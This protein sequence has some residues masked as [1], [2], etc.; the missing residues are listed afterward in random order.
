MSW[1]IVKQSMRAA[2][3][4]V[5]LAFTGASLI[6]GTLVVER[7]VFQH[8][9][10]AAAQKVVRAEE[11]T[12][13]ILLLDERLTMS[14]NMAAGT[15][16]ERWITR[17]EANISPMDE[18]I[19][20]ATEL[21][22]SDVAARFDAETRVANDLLVE[23]ERQ[24]FALV[25]EGTLSQARALL[26]GQA[27]AE[28]KS[29]L[30]AGTAR[31]TASLVTAMEANL[32]S[33]RMHAIVL[34]GLLTIGGFGLLW[35]L[36]TRS[37]TRSEAAFVQAERHIHDLAMHDALTDLANRRG[38]TGALD[39]AV[40]EA[41]TSGRTLTLLTLDLDRFKP[42]NDLYGHG[43]GDAVL[44]EVAARLTRLVPAGGTAAR[45][46]GD[47]FA[48][49]LTQTAIEDVSGVSR[50][51]ADALHEPIRSA[52][53][54][55]PVQIGVSIGIASHPSD[56]ADATTL[57]THA[58]LALYRAKNE[59]RGSIREFE[60]GMVLE[61]RERG[62]IEI[63]VGRAIADGQIVPHFQP[64]VDLRTQQ[65]IGFE[66]LARWPHPERGMIGPDVFIP[67]AQRAGLI[68]DLT[69]SILR[70]ACQVAA[71]WSVPLPIALNIAPEQL[72]DRWLPEKLLGVLAEQGFPAGRLEIEITENAL[73][74]DFETARRV[75][76]SLKNQ[77]VRIALDDFGSGCSSLSHLSQL[78]IDKIKID[79][80]F[81]K[82]ITTHP[83]SATIV[84]AI[85]GLSRSLSMTTIAEGI[86]EPALVDHL[87]TLGC[88]L[89]QGFLFSRPLCAQD[90]GILVQNLA[91][92][93]GEPD[94]RA[95]DNDRGLRLYA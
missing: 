47:E 4:V 85:I 73:V 25:R 37:L 5:L 50:R 74:A 49:L 87:L 8:L 23:L 9:Y 79:R 31:F 57:L 18:A 15:G 46:G 13:Q 44:R 36:L 62:A 42:I 56:A 80:S 11:L 26:D 3:R 19:N 14:A 88:D 59:G 66:V 94:G 53:L 71:R 86:E 21:A 78:P 84:S 35:F 40:A 92:V 39:T 72:Q 45:L 7:L 90:T 28:Q 48:V 93:C 81:V 10:A 29:I 6:V 82:S 30:A 32:A 83:Q 89:G 77:G 67:I 43:A 65:V 63:E 1:S 60:P 24:S 16:E 91:D 55:N 27:Y 17:Y 22:P 52:T 38:F 68:T 33:V 41:R 2:R 34:V 12:G 64:L 61:T 69:L 70:Q 95:T 75:I 51:I 20:A 54:P 58:D 76:A